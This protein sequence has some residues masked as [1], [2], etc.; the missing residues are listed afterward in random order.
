VFAGYATLPLVSLGLGLL[1]AAAVVSV[2]VLMARTD[3]F[4]WLT[5]LGANSIVIYLAF[6]L[7][8]AAT[9]TLLIKT[10]VIADVGIM[11][12]IVTVMGVVLPLCLFW[13]VRGTRA[14]F[15][16]E[17]PARFWLTGKPLKKSATLQP[18]E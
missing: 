10:G 17:R 6:F 4:G 2:A 5:Y 3:R 12:V 1:G 16:F 11:S 7:P 15:L 8:M 9:R 13:L 18:A 14:S